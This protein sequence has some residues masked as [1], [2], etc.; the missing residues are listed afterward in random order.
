MARVA[1]IGPTCINFSPYKVNIRLAQPGRQLARPLQGLALIMREINRP[2][3]SGVVGRV[4]I[5][6]P[7][8][9]R[10]HQP[11]SAQITVACQLFLR[12]TPGSACVNLHQNL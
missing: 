6:N 2:D 11:L 3:T 1:E 12:R 10:L 8:G 5:F 9:Q 7:V 4:K